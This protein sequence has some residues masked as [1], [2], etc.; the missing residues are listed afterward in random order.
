MDQASDGEKEDDDQEVEIDEDDQ[1][2]SGLQATDLP[3]ALKTDDKL[4]EEVA[5]DE[6]E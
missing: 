1:I 2:G 5:E 3:V 4:S 6:A